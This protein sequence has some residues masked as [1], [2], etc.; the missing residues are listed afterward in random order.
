MEK[1]EERSR[2]TRRRIAVLTD[3]WV[4]LLDRVDAELG[5]DRDDL[6]KLLE[7]TYNMEGLSPIKGKATPP[8]IFEK[9]LISLYV[10]GRYGMQLY[11]D[12][13]E[14]FDR[15]FYNEMKYD[16]AVSYLLSGDPQKAR[17]LIEMMFGEVTMNLLAKIFRVMVVRELFGFNGEEK[18]AT[19]ISSTVKA[20]PEHEEGIKKYLRFYIAIKVADAISRGEIRDRITKEVWKQA[21]ALRLGYDKSVIPDDAYIAHIAREVFK[22]P[23][24]VLAKLLRL[25]KQG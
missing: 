11:E 7:D 12:F 10:V 1:H 21:L 16:E 18:F 17:Q 15:L 23:R 6:I 8:D 25:K 9:E 22:V 3:I 24:R 20:F 14:I 2:I 13:P 5:F 4:K 19:L